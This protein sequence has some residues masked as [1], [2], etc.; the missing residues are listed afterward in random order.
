MKCR[1][2]CVYDSWICYYVSRET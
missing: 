1:V 2:S